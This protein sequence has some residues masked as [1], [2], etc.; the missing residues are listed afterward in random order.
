MCMLCRSLFVLF[1]LA[2]VLSVLQFTDSDYLFDIFKPIY[3]IRGEHINYI[4]HF[5][6]QNDSIYYKMNYTYSISSK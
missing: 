1:L 4:I 5:A 6:V 3:R 2:I